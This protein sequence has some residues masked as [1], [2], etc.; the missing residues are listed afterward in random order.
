MKYDDDDDFL[1][2]EMNLDFDCLY[3][4]CRVFDSMFNLSVD[5][6]FVIFMT[7]CAEKLPF[8]PNETYDGYASAF[9]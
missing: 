1:S 2:D 9:C 5:Q 8:L 4:F 3:L 6:E 7:W